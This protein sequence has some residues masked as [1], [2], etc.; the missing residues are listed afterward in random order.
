M[1]TATR[2]RPGSAPTSSVKGRSLAGGLHQ[3]SGSGALTTSR[4]AAASATVRV[5]TPS[6]DRPDQPGTVS[7]IRPRLGLWP[8][9]PQH[10]AGMRIDPPPSLALAAGNIPDATAAAAP[11]LDPPGVKARFHGLRVA[12][13]RSFSVTLID[14]NSGELVRPQRM[15]PASTKAVA[16]S[17]DRS[18][19]AS[20]APFDP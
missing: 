5:T 17:S 14:P 11:P 7:A 3:A 2:R 16:T 6:T 10:D 13:N 19:G 12:P 15:N 8:T 9:S 18:A 1:L 4:M 20:E